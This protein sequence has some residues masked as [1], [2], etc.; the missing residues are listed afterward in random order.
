MRAIA[1]V[2]RDAGHDIEGRDANG[3][4]YFYAMLVEGCCPH[5]DHGIGCALLVDVCLGR[6]IERKALRAINQLLGLGTVSGCSPNATARL[7]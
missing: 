6:A 5:R 4:A 1:F 2:G 7:S 3:F